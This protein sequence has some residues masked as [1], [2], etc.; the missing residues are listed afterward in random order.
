MRRRKGKRRNDKEKKM[1]K[2]QKEKEKETKKPH[3]RVLFSDSSDSSVDVTSGESVWMDSDEEIK[4][5]ER[6]RQ[7]VEKFVN[8][9]VVFKYDGKFSPG[10]ITAVST[11][12]ATVSSMIRSGRLWKWPEKPDVLSYSS[13]EILGHIDEQK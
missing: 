9:F 2:E 12:E 10:K 8:E 1:E 13:E 6:I 5:E 4:K 3:R 7:P 11:D